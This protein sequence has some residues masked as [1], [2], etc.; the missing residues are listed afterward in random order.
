MSAI[1]NLFKAVAMI[2]VFSL[3]TRALGFLFKVYLSRELGAYDG[4]TN[5]DKYLVDLVSDIYVDWRV[6]L[7]LVTM[8]FI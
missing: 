4:T 8:S 6:S 5:D 7:R 3:V 2:S 1:R